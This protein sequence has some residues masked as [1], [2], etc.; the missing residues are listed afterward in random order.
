MPDKSLSKEEKEKLEFL[1]LSEQNAII[2]SKQSVEWEIFE[3]ILEHIKK[4]RDLDLAKINNGKRNILPILATFV[5]GKDNVVAWQYISV[6]FRTR[7]GQLL[8]SKLK[9]LI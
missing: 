3:F 9:R 1:I 7:A 8:L 6:D 2:A 5:I 4:D